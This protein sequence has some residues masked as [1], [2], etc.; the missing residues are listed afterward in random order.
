MLRIQEIFSTVNGEGP[1]TG[2][3]FTIVR[4]A[5]PKEIEQIH[6][7]APKTSNTLMSIEKVY[8]TISRCQKS[9]KVA[10][11]GYEPTIQKDFVDLCR[12]LNDRRLFLLLDT[13][14]IIEVPTDIINYISLSPKPGLTCNSRVIKNAQEFRFYWSCKNT[15]LYE[16]NINFYL[17]N[18]REDQ[19]LT[20]LPKEISQQ[21]IDGVIQYCLEHPRF[22]ANI[23]L[24]RTFPTLDKNFSPLQKGA[25]DDE[26]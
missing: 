7:Q 25:Q 18:I 3:V 12:Y 24:Y 2:E 8:Q 22:R 9:S 6:L 1:Y 21:E 26:V 4:F 17:P 23:P 10:L 5:Y 19:T 14:G 15:L 20:L 13:S 16:D 11:M